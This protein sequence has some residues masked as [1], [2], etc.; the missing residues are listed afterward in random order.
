METKIKSIL[1]NEKEFKGKKSKSYL[2]TIADGTT[3]YLDSKVGDDFKE[4]DL[5][6]CVIEGK[7]SA[8]GKAYNFFVL[9]KLK[10]AQQPTP[11]KEKDVYETKSRSQSDIRN[12]VPF[13]AMDRIIDLIIAGKVP[14][15]KAKEYYKELCTYLYDEINE[16]F[17]EE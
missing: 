17:R 13:R 7:T 3:G 4:G 1:I 10:S 8:A 11:K 5:V 6:D 2:V 16:C 9:T 14:W 15:E 12:E